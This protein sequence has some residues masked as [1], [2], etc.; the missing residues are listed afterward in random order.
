MSIAE[1]AEAEG[2]RVP[3]ISRSGSRHCVGGQF[4]TLTVGNGVRTMPTSGSLARY[5]RDADWSPYSIHAPSEP[6]N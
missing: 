6:L 2:A 3:E 5:D 1:P 4:L